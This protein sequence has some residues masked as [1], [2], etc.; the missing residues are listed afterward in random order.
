MSEN[1]IFV[2]L[3]EIRF[4]FSIVIFELYTTRFRSDKYNYLKW[5]AS[6][7]ICLDRNNGKLLNLVAALLYKIKMKEIW[8][9]LFCL[10]ILSGT[11]S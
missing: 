8:S 4:R 3:K 5:S 7:L 9:I 6:R 10:L 2:S 11:I 1:F